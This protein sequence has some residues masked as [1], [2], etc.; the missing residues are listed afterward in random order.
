MPRIPKYVESH[1]DGDFSEIIDVRSENEFALDHIPGA[2]N[3]PVLNN[4][5]RVRVGTIYVRQSSFVAKRLGAA[6]IAENIGKHLRS[7]FADKG[8]EYRPLVYCW[9]GG[10]RSEALALVLAQIGWNVSLL[11]G[12]YKRYRRSVSADLEVLPKQ[13]EYRVLAGLTGTGKT[14]LL[15]ELEKAGHQVLNLEELACHRGSLLGEEPGQTQ[16]SQKYFDSLLISRLR[17]LSPSKPVW[18][19]SE[20]FKIGKISLPTTLWDKLR[21]APCLEVV[22]PLEVRVEFLLREYKHFCENPEHLI[23]KIKVLTP[24]YGKLKIGVWLDH[25]EKRDWEKFVTAMLQEHYDRAYS[26]ALEKNYKGSRKVVFLG[27]SE[28]EAN[29][30]FYSE[31]NTLHDGL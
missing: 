12:G 25:I 21:A 18:V 11:K 23:E 29:S 28:Y 13:F 30:K 7:H 3:F 2:L 4:L 9:R 16:P 24:L 10:Q 6:I 26:M 31:A 22:R 20:G 8:E 27:G 17:A 15:K 5:E 14:A 1:L 19:E